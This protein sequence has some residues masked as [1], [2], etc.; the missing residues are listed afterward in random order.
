MIEFIL[1]DFWRWLGVTTW[2]CIFVCWQPVRVIFQRGA[3]NEA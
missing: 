2:L 1:S 3:N